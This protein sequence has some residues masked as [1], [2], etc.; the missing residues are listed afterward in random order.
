[1]TAKQILIETAK[2]RRLLWDLGK[3]RRDCTEQE[4][5]NIENA[6]AF[7]EENAM[8][9]I[10]NNQAIVYKVCNSKNHKLKTKIYNIKK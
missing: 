1:M 5:R 9:W 10:I 2:S 4:V 3:G 7:S 6:S 8:K